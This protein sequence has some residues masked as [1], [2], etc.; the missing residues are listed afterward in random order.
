MFTFFALGLKDAPRDISFR[1]GESGFVNGRA[2][3]VEVAEGRPEVGGSVAVAVTGSRDGRVVENKRGIE[4]CGRRADA[5][6]RQRVQI[7]VIWGW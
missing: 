6:R 2:M 4:D 1:E 7:M 5:R 3:P